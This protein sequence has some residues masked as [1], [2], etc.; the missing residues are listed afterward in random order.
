M[1]FVVVVVV[2]PTPQPP[3]ASPEVA[4]DAGE[5]HLDSAEERRQHQDQ[6][7]HDVLEQGTFHT[8]IHSAQSTRRFI[9]TF[10]RIN[11]YDEVKK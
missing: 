6:K 2:L 5:E 7:A 1:D 8:Y 10:L 11:K 9:T 4:S 3:L